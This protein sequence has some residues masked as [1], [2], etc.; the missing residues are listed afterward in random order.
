MTICKNNSDPNRNDTYG[1]DGYT[2][3]WWKQNCLDKIGKQ[4]YFGSKVEFEYFDKKGNKIVVDEETMKIISIEAGDGKKR[5]MKSK[6]KKKKKR[7]KKKK[8]DPK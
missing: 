8:N 4:S 3:C 1:K 6:K 7:P 2:N 5:V